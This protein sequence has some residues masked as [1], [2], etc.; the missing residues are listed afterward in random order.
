[1]SDPVEILKAKLP[2]RGNIPQ[3]WATELLTAL[4]DDGWRVIKTDADP[5]ATWVHLDEE[6]TP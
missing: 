4:R 5:H 2:G 1:V 6:W 3:Q